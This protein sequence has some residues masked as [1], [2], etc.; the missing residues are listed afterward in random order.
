MEDDGVSS[1]QPAG[2]VQVSPCLAVPLP[3]DGAGTEGA[4]PESPVGG[5]PGG[6]GRVCAPPATNPPSR[7]INPSSAPNTAP[8]WLRMDGCPQLSRR[9]EVTVSEY[10]GCPSTSP[11][12]RD[13]EPAAPPSRPHYLVPRVPVPCGHG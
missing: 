4:F 9:I 13:T 8:R 11:S 2:K 12:A 1:A 10:E 5:W 6:S 3:G 7:T